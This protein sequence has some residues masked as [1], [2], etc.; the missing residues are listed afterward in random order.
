VATLLPEL[1][2][3]SIE[4]S[5]HVLERE[6]FRSGVGKYRNRAVPSMAIQGRDLAKASRSAI[7]VS[8]SRQR[9]ELSGVGIE[10]HASVTPIME[11]AWKLHRKNG[12]PAGYTGPCWGPTLDELDQ[13]R[14]IVTARKR[15]E[16]KKRD[17]VPAEVATETASGATEQRK[18]VRGKR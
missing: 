7:A 6:Q 11:E 5:S 3:S 1:Q 9:R 10:A 18:P 14:V 16:T 15:G 2:T 17:S 13:A 4:G 12:H 8:E